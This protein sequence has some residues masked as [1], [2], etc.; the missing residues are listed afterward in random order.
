M[1][2]T[3]IAISPKHRSAKLFIRRK[4]SNAKGALYQGVKLIKKCKNCK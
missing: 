4:G 2:S 1:S 3:E